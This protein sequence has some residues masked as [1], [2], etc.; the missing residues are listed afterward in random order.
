MIRADDDE[1]KGSPR[2]IECIKPSR[3]AAESRSGTNA[4]NTNARQLNGL[5]P[6]LK[7]L[8]SSSTCVLSSSHFPRHFLFV[9]YSIFQFLL[10][11]FESIHPLKNAR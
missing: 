4:C 9:F 3:C 7:S 8:L 11:V 6:K 5:V 2:T 1:G 10:T